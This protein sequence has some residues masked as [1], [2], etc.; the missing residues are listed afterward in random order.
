MEIASILKFTDLL[1]RGCL[2]SLSEASYLQE[3]FRLPLSLFIIIMFPLRDASLY[4]LTAWFLKKHW[5][6]QA[7]PLFT[8]VDLW[9]AVVSQEDIDILSLLLA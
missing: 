1:G 7:H 3:T 9:N 4:S 8:L 6:L 2:V 5:K